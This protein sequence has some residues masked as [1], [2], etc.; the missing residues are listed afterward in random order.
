MEKI[1]DSFNGR[2][3]NELNPEDVKVIEGYWKNHELLKRERNLLEKVY[4]ADELNADIRYPKLV[5]ILDAIEKVYGELNE[6]FQRFIQVRYW[7]EL[8]PTYEYS[9]VADILEVSVA[10]T[11]KIRTFVMTK[12]AKE[13]GYITEP[14]KI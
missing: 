5:A 10:K 14:I 9:E 3:L 8:S 6:L 2:E 12:T 13:L 7:E 1:S 4:V 11:Y